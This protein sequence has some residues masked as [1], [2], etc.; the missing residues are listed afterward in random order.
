[1]YYK[2]NT[3]VSIT[4]MVQT[5]QHR[6]AI[7]FTLLKQLAALTPFHT[8]RCFKPNESQTPVF[9]ASPNSPWQLLKL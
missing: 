1:M 2:C 6:N 7:V 9:T 5:V 8:T 4:L 3:D